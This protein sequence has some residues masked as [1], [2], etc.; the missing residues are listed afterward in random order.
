MLP[1]LNIPLPSLGSN[2]GADDA[3]SPAYFDVSYLDQELLFI[4]Q[5]QPGGAFVLVRETS[6]ERRVREL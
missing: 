4:L 5:N 2:A 3:S 1:T 6:D